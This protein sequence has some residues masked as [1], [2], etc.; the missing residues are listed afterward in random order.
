M[1]EFHPIADVFPLIAGDEFSDL[2]SDIRARGLL[3]P[4]WIYDGQILDGRNRYRACIEAGIPPDY[5]EYQ[6]DDPIGF[7]ISLNLRRRHLDESQRGMVAARLANLGWGQRADRAANW[8]LLPG[9]PAPATPITQADAAA[10]LNVGERSVS[11]AREVLDGGSL[12]SARPPVRTDRTSSR[13][14]PGSGGYPGV[15]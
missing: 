15:T 10:L 11:R 2:V 6:G 7:V 14:P 8:Q 13:L 3:E 12:G 1:M 4:I 9:I 5:R